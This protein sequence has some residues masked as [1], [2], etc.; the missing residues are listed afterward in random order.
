MALA[1]DWMEA[2]YSIRAKSFTIYTD[3]SIHEAGQVG[4]GWFAEGNARTA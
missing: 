2:T 3:G 4:G 1:G